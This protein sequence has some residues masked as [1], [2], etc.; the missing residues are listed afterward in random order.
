M[1]LR[2]DSEEMP[3]G[4]AKGPGGRMGIISEQISNTKLMVEGL[5]KTT[6]T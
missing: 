1:K 5:T 3:L 6:P 2:Q 4:K